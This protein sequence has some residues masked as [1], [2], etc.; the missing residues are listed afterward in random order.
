MAAVPEIVVVPFTRPPSVVSTIRVG[1]CTHPANGSMLSRPA[2]KRGGA[3]ASA[4]ALMKQPLAR[5][6]VG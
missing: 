1:G 2:A 3:S 6:P 5:R 4:D